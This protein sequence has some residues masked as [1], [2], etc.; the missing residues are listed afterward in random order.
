MKPF[1]RYLSH[2]TDL[3]KFLDTYLEMRQHFQE[4]DFS[5][6]DLERPPKYTEKMMIFHNKISNLQLSL[7]KQVNDFGFDV[8]GNEFYEFILPLMQ[9][10]NELTP[11]KD[12]NTEG[13]NIGNEDY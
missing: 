1:E 9:K 11:L 10:I 13:R 2:L 5:E 12:G 8:S 7:L 6:E 4:L 3:R